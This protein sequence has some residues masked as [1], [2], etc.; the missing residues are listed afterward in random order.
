MSCDLG[1]QNIILEELRT[2]MT[3]NYMLSLFHTKIF[4][5]TYFWSQLFPE[6]HKIGEK[7]FLPK[8]EKVRFLGTERKIVIFRENMYIP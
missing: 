1:F 5:V 6:M 8:T 4:V 2:Y 7:S 3:K